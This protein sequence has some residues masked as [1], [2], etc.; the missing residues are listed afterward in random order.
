MTNILSSI[1]LN[2][3]IRE[4]INTIRQTKTTSNAAM[5]IEAIGQFI[6]DG[7]I[8]V[9]LAKGSTV[10]S[11]D[12]YYIEVEKVNDK[13]CFIFDY[14]DGNPNKIFGTLPFNGNSN[15][16]IMYVAALYAITLCK[17]G[18]ESVNDITSSLLIDEMTSILLKCCQ[19]KTLWNLFSLTL[20]SPYMQNDSLPEPILGVLK[21]E[22][23]KAEDVIFKE[24]KTTSESPVNPNEIEYHLLDENRIYNT[25]EEERIANNKLVEGYV[26]TTEDK[27]Y[28]KRIYNYIKE[29]GHAPSFFFYGPAGTGKSEKGKYFAKVLGLPYTFICCSAMTNESDLRGKPQNVNSSGNLVKFFKDTVK[30]LWKKDIDTRGYDDNKIQYSLTEL[31]LACKY[32]WVI[33]IQEPSLIV[34]AGTLG[35][36]NCVLDTNR[37]LILP[38]GS[39]IKVHPNTVFIFTTNLNYEG[40]NLMNN[41]LLSRIGYVKRV[42]MPTLEEQTERIVSVTGFKGPK[43]E[44]LQLLKAIKE[45]N[46][47]M[48]E[49]GITQGV[50][51]LRCAIECVRDHML[52]NC[53]WRESAHLTIEDKAILEDG[54]ENQVRL[55]LDSYFGTI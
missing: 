12:V 47:M 38:D 36:L 21:G 42:D 19:Q 29:I 9:S 44:I 20:P 32:G 4:K 5:V 8:N 51:D 37:T 22:F 15:T 49:D 52:N 41:A 48:K 54:F 31:V 28:A 14:K 10:L 27:L 39:E 16:N 34:N 24:F 1:C 25:M 55:K 26:P 35:F 30:A 6:Q 2:K 17:E 18:V 53:S 45:I 11:P 23:V 3:D 50:C 13:V 40:C 7:T 33:E 43:G 46:H